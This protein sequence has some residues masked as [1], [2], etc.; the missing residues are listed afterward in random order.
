MSIEESKKLF[1]TDFTKPSS[2]A[3]SLLEQSSP[4]YDILN[5]P[6]QPV[7]DLKSTYVS[8]APPKTTSEGFLGFSND[9]ISGFADLGAAGLGLIN[10]LDNLKTNKLNRKGMELNLKTMKERFNNYQSS[11]QGFNNYV[12]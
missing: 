2:L 9:Q 11:R 7:A 5:Q 4:Y 12:A 3:E 6:V 1:S 8:T 10:T